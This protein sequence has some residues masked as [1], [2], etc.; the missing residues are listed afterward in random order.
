MKKIDFRITDQEKYNDKV[1]DVDV[2]GLK[3]GHK[4]IVLRHYHGQMIGCNCKAVL[5]SKKLLQ[6]HG[7]KKTVY[8]SF[9]SCDFMEYL[10]YKRPFI[11]S[12]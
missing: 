3:Y 10:H 5:L 9:R 1:I 4:Y 7:N 8:T 6:L 11:N 12:N 2:S